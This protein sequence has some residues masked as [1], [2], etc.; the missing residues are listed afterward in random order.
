[1]TL[2]G[3]VMSSE[4]RSPLHS[5]P[6][7]SW[8]STLSATFSLPI[9]DCDP[10]ACDRVFTTSKGATTRAV[11]TAPE[12][13]DTIEALRPETMT[14]QP[15]PRLLRWPP[16]ARRIDRSRDLQFV[17]L[18]SGVKKDH[19]P[20]LLQHTQWRPGGISRL[21]PCAASVCGASVRGVLEDGRLG[22]HA[23]GLRVEL[24]D[25]ARAVLGD[26]LEVRLR[27]WEARSDALVPSRAVGRPG[28][29]GRGVGGGVLG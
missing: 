1:M 5:A 11:A 24:L 26:G 2:A 17:D 28:C 7:P 16:P 8:R 25:Q 27:T 10:E 6:T 19:A 15:A 20:C 21:P 13:A 14:V 12:L 23:D 18:S 22:E 29:G 3:T 4:G 9:T